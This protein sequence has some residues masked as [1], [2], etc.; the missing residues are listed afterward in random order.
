MYLYEG[1]RDPICMITGDA[2]AALRVTKTPG[3]EPA[4]PT[5]TG[6]QQERANKLQIIKE[7]LVTFGTAATAKKAGISTDSVKYY[8]RELGIR[9]FGH[10]KHGH[11]VAK[12]GEYGNVS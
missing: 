3:G 11:W 1:F 2:Y 10:P 7:N 5:I 12:G 9:F 8:V 6:T 4:P